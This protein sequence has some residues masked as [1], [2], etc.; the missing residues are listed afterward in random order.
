MK[1]E[2]ERI[3][4]IIN[5]DQGQLTDLPWSYLCYFKILLYWYFLLSESIRRNCNLNIKIECDQLN[6]TYSTRLYYQILSMIKSHQGAIDES[7][8][9][10]DGLKSYAQK[11][12]HDD[13]K[14]AEYYGKIREFLLCTKP[15]K[16]VDVL[17]I[18]SILFWVNLQQRWL[19]IINTNEHID[20]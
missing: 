8:K 16:W 5:I 4:T 1:L 2:D 12:S 6:D 17:K 19:K 15:D 20:L 18:S 11:L 10:F 9:M 7:V 13:M 14:L 3:W